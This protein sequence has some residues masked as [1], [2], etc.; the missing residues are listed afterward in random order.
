MLEWRGRLSVSAGNFLKNELLHKYFYLFYKYLG[1][2]IWRKSSELLLVI[3]SVRV[4]SFSLPQRK[5]NLLSQTRPPHHLPNAYLSA[6]IGHDFMDFDFI[7]TVNR[8]SI[9]PDALSF[10]SARSIPIKQ[11]VNVLPIPGCKT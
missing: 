2:L 10:L 4:S 1:A 5:H 8:G 11:I 7:S 3:L 6:V 9:C